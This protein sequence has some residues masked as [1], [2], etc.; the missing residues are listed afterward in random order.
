MTLWA[1][2]PVKP[3]HQ[4]KSRLSGM[5]SSDEREILNLF[6]L[7]HT[8]E[9][10][11]S[12]ELVNRILV[13]SKDP[14]V[15]AISREYQAV[16]LHAEDERLDLNLDL[17][18]ADLM[19][20]WMG[21]TDI[22]VLPADLPLITVWDVYQFIQTAQKPKL[23]VIAPDRN[24]DGTNGLLFSPAD[25]SRYAFGSGSFERHCSLASKAGYHIEIFESE[26]FAL[27]LDTPEDLNLLFEKAPS[28]FQ[29]FAK[30]IRRNV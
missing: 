5:L 20:K 19:A 4:G 11:S 10:L 26:T 6:L 1:I 8:L 9:I 13:V 7:R 14:Q 16:T 23:L 3:L 2:V 12:V 28:F 27:D 24:R 25:G 18:K 15:L 21:A 17:Q 30:P 22:F 29:K